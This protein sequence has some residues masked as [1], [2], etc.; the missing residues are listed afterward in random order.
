MDLFEQFRKAEK[1]I[2]EKY[3]ADGDFTLFG[4]FER[5]DIPGKYDVIVS[6]YWLIGGLGSLTI[7]TRLVQE[8]IG[9]GW[10]RQIGRFVIVPQEDPLISAVL[11]RLP[12]EGIRHD[13]RV[14][15]D[16]VYEHDVIRRAV[17]ITAIHPY[18]ESLTVTATLREPV[19]LGTRG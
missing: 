5:D 1:T 18:Q 16:L 11:E 10:W 2:S 7:L 9:T 13:L 3:E 19:S 4:L 8:A 6:A 14:L 17:I 15:T 12:P